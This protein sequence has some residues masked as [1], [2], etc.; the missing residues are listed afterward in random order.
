M[1]IVIRL[2]YPATSLSHHARTNCQLQVSNYHPPRIYHQNNSY[3][4]YMKVKECEQ[5][6]SQRL[7]NKMK[8]RQDLIS[9]MSF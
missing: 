1:V 9:I 4:V 2:R 5:P 6:V 7:Y 8:L 3:A